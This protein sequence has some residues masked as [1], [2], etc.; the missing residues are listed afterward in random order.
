[1]TICK[2]AENEFSEGMTI[3]E[4]Y[5]EIIELSSQFMAMHGFKRSGRSEIFYKYNADKSKGF[6]ISFRKSLDNSP[7]FCKFFIK[8]GS[9]SID[10]LYRTGS[11]RDKIRFEDLKAT[12]MHNGY[13]ACDSCHV[14]DPFIIEIQSVNDYYQST[15]LPELNK[16]VNQFSLRL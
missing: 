13:S 15:I 7:E 4:Y 11:C 6:I 8:F 5:A 2:K 14:L 1:M 12:I 10:E 16:I 3:K 9:L